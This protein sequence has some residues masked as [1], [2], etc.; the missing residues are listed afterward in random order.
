MQHTPW[1]YVRRFETF[2]G[3]IYLK[4]TP[5]QLALDATII[6]TLHDQFHAPVPIVIADNSELNCFLMKDAGRPY[7]SV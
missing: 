7:E 5:E 4:Q 2:E 6:K 3:Y 1:S